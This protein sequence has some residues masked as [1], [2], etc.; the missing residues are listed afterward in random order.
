MVLAPETI[1]WMVLA[2]GKGALNEISWDEHQDHVVFGDSSIFLI[3]ISIQKDREIKYSEAN[4]PTKGQGLFFW[5]LLWRGWMGLLRRACFQGAIP[6]LCWGWWYHSKNPKKKLKDFECVLFFKWEVYRNHIA[7]PNASILFAQ[8]FSPC[9][10]VI[11]AD[12]DG[13][14]DDHKSI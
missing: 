1:L 5:H 6:P 10:I 7:H 4:T 11:A 9:G 14:A 3:K 8:D 12:T 2:P 13:G